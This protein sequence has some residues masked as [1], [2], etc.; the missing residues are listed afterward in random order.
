MFFNKS[1]LL[2]HINTM[3]SEHTPKEK[4][5]FATIQKAIE[6]ATDP[7]ERAYMPFFRQSDVKRMGDR[8]RKLEDQNEQLIS[9]V[10][11]LLDRVA[12]LT[13]S[14]GDISTNLQQ[15]EKEHKASLVESRE[16]IVN[17]EKEKPVLTKRETDVFGLLAKGFCA[18][19]IAKT[20]FISETTVI[21]HKRNLKEKFHARNTVE[22]ITNVLQCRCF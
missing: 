20:L 18:K 2:S 8:I 15:E 10:H 13:K 16:E 7:T 3:I 17:P 4:F 12:S 21:T 22:L 5:D 1:D 9:V 19:E 14:I 6:G 11:F